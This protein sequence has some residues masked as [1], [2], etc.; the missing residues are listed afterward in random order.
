LVTLATTDKQWSTE[1]YQHV[2]NSSTTCRDATTAEAAPADVANVCVINNM[3]L[4]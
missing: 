3:L 2:T 4:W 1:A